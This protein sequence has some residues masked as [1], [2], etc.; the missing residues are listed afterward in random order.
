MTSLPVKI[1]KTIEGYAVLN[2][3]VVGFSSFRDV[4]KHHFLTAA[5]KLFS[6]IQER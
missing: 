3:E 1:V 6:W 5:A 2:F 4:Q